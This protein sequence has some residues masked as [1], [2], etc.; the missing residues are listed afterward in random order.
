MREPRAEILVAV[1]GQWASGKSTAART[2]V[3]HLGG[4]DRVVFINDAVRLTGQVLNHIRDLE[5]SNVK[6]SME[7]DGRQR[8]WCEQATLWL[9]PGED[10]ETVDPNTL[11]FDMPDHALCD[12]LT[13]AR[14]GD[15]IRSCGLTE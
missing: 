2:L 3:G 1:L 15:I 10:L 6:V 11:A 5:D 8:L 4:E 13:R 14:A 9:G 7:E 12:W